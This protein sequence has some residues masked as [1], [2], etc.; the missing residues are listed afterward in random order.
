M[1]KLTKLLT[2][3]ITTVFAASMLMPTAL[4]LPDKGTPVNFGE[5]RALVIDHSDAEIYIDPELVELL[6]QVDIYI[7]EIGMIEKEGGRAKFYADVCI[8]GKDIDTLSLHFD[9]NGI[10]NTF[11]YSNDL[12]NEE[13]KRYYS[14][15]YQYY[16]L[17]PG[18]VTTLTVTVDYNE[19]EEETDET[20]N[21]LTTVVTIPEEPTAPDPFETDLFFDEND[22]IGV[23]ED[24]S[25]FYA[26][27]CGID[28]G[29]LLGSS[30]EVLFEVNGQSEVTTVAIPDSY[31]CN[32]AYVNVPSNFTLDYDV[33][34]TLTVTIDPT[35]QIDEVQD[36][37]NNTLDLVFTIPTPEP[38]PEPEPTV[39]LKVTDVGVTGDY[40]YYYM[41]VYGK[42]TDGTED[43]ELS[44]NAN[45]YDHLLTVTA[46]ADGESQTY[47]SVDTA[48]FFTELGN[49]YTITATVDPND[50]IEETNEDNN[51]GT[52][53]YSLPEPQPA[54]E[55]DELLFR[56]SLLLLRI[57]DLD[58]PDNN[59]SLATYQGSLETTDASLVQL[60]T[61][62]PLLFEE[63]LD[64]DTYTD[65][66]LGAE[67][68]ISTYSHWDGLVFY[69]NPT[70]LDNSTTRS[71]QLTIDGYVNEFIV[72]EEGLTTYDIGDGTG[73]Q[74]EVLLLTYLDTLGEE[75][76]EQLSKMVENASKLLESISISGKSLDESSDEESEETFDTL[77]TEMFLD[78]AILTSDNA[79]DT[80][81]TVLDET[82][83]ENALDT[84]ESKAETLEE[85]LYEEGVNPFTDVSF[86]DKCWYCEYV[87]DIKNAGIISGYKDVSGVLTGE[88]KPG[89]DITIAEILKI[90]LKVA[91]EEASEADPNLSQALDHWAKGYVA[92]AEE[93][94]LEIVEDSE[95]DL[96]RPATRGEVLQILLEALGA[97]TPTYSTST[98]YFTDL[99][100]SHKNFNHIQYSYDLGLVSGDDNAS[101]FRPDDGINR[102]E[103]SKIAI[104]S[105]EL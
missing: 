26:N 40:N 74:V 12:P 38:E 61:V 102:A 31:T 28:T 1:R 98:S 39:D 75:T 13:C 96:N 103:V 79:I 17:E 92:K 5:E 95:L 16:F 105:L 36:V 82:T 32:G 58:G 44:F 34:Y 35:D 25:T 100:A 55:N 46:P 52:H 48:Y 71:L 63:I 3:A 59:N 47:Y 6:N 27:V 33:L 14:W 99:D 20:N 77:V 8:E 84:Y 23:Y 56:P 64:N 4:A 22:S 86:D 69:V 83:L 19:Y 29:D 50:L 87:T 93:L 54:P 49:T 51:T 10:S 76:P 66:T 72:A 81:K 67:F 80:V 30:V 62:G 41:T 37:L 73:N 89:N 65:T 88:F 91:G 9:A 85:I 53:T 78:T 15:N 45:G 101:T 94:G 7:E 18:E 21:T 104:K 97:D 57:G 42:N 43:I 60:E 11:S 24:Y 90:A 68:T 70:S 2:G